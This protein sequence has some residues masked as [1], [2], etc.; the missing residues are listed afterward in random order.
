MEADGYR[1]ERRSLCTKEQRKEIRTLL[2]GNAIEKTQ[3]YISDILSSN[4]LL[5]K[6]LEASKSANDKT[7]PER[8]AEE[9]GDILTLYGDD[10]EAI[11]TAHIT[12]HGFYKKL[13]L[14]FW[15]G[16]STE[17]VRERDKRK[18]HYLKKDSHG[19]LFPNDIRKIC[20][21]PKVTAIKKYH[22]DEVLT[23]GYIYSGC[24]ILNEFMG[25][26]QD[27][28]KRTEASLELGLGLDSC[29]KKSIG[30]MGKWLLDNLFGLKIGDRKKHQG[31]WVHFIESGDIPRDAIFGFWE[32]NMLTDEIEQPD[33]APEPE[34]MAT[35]I[36]P[37]SVPEKP[38][39]NRTDF[40][41]LIFSIGK[42]VLASETFTS[43]NSQTTEHFFENTGLSFS[44]AE[45]QP[46]LGQNFTPPSAPI[47][48]AIAPI[49]TTPEPEP[50]AIAA[51]PKYR[52]GDRLWWWSI[53]GRK[54]LEAQVIKAGQR[55][56]EMVIRLI[57]NDHD[58][59]LDG[60]DR[61]APV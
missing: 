41:Q 3:Q 34:P 59:Y 53:C 12:E 19:K 50:V 54:W 60:G 15:L 26:L 48:T 40:E 21:T 35:A 56:E 25:I 20:I 52:Q 36:A 47:A 29:P 30:S 22:F 39:E 11:A 2:K 31:I 43:R 14:H 57:A 4:A 8:C 49:I 17:S 5:G 51:T 58:V 6:A 10:S 27:E 7:Y 37:E 55:L 24:P 46:I 23:R 32:Q 13:Q 18:L 42:S 38:T 61:I 44:P 9:H 28:I 45:N 1:I 16:Q 33:F